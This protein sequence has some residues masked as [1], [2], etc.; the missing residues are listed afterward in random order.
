MFDL[1]IHC[2]VLSGGVFNRGGLN[3]ALLS[4][5]FGDM[6]A[7]DTFTDTLMKDC[8]TLWCC[9]MHIHFPKGLQL[10]IHKT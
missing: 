7:F 2:M 1:E 8:K 5:F 3:S 10:G 6:G 4:L 9:C